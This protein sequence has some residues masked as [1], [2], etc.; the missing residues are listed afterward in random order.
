MSALAQALRR[1]A[2]VAFSL[3]LQPLWFRILKWIGGL[4]FC[5]AFQDRPW[6]WPV[7][8]I[9]TLAALT[10]HFLYR[11]KT[12]AWTQPWGGWDDL[13]AGRSE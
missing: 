10:V 8:A 11:W 4:A 9:S 5:L 2:R 12:R 3:R 7:I 6:F 1:E 13:T